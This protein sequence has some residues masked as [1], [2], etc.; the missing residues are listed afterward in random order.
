ML[1]VPSEVG[2]VLRPLVPDGGDG[3]LAS[4]AR[5]AIASPPGRL[6]D[7]TVVLAR[8]HPEPLL[9]F[10]GDL[11]DADLVRLAMLRERLA[12]LP[13]RLR[14][15]DWAAVDRAVE[16]LAEQLVEQLGDDGLAEVRL[17]GV[18]RGG[19][20]VLGLL[21]VRLG[22][23]SPAIGAPDPARPLVVVDD[24]AV[25]GAR[26]REFLTGLGHPDVVVAILAAHPEL[27]RLLPTAVPG[28]RTA[29]AAVDLHD[30]APARHGDDH[31]AWQRRWQQRHPGDV[32]TGHPDLVAFPW[33]EPDNAFWNP[34]TAREE[35]GWRVLPAEACLK[36]RPPVGDGQDTIVA[37]HED[38]PGYLRPPARVLAARTGD[39][40]HVVD[41]QGAVVRLRD[42]AL[43]FWQAA[44][45]APSA[46]AAVGRLRD[47]YPT[48]PASLRED[49]VAFAAA[50]RARSL[51][52]PVAGED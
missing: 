44:T 24:C 39:E 40:L 52:V 31:A 2:E 29:V 26:L 42:T 35:V 25:S 47:R 15:L 3:W 9:A 20:I 33:N 46:E 27:R 12:E 49:F 37:V 48:A 43:A 38:T 19:L 4:V 18:P 11:S 41:A 21:A 22:L 1:H 50:L 34:E 17:V 51:L 36:N 10:V 5:S 13:A 32:W 7:A 30:H 16:R 28:V 8:A 14:F 6:V 23:G 45:S